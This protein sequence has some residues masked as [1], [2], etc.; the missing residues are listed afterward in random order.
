MWNEPSRK[1]LAAIPKLYET[2]ETPL[3][4]KLIHLHFFIAGC[5]WFVA[6]YDGDDLF[7]GFAILNQDFEMAEF[8]YVSFE[9]LKA[10]KVKGWLEV[11]CE[12][13][14]AWRVRR[15]VELEK[16]RMAQGWEKGGKS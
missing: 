11:D 15:A 3:Q 5:D 12:T 10:I 7:W 13:E 1:R 16:I 8:G 6:E 2:E 4:E 9:E 14:E